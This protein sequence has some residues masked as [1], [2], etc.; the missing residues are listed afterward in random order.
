L[1]AAKLDARSR[2]VADIVGAF[3]RA[4]LHPGVVSG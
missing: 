2:S 4:G 1:Q 3:D